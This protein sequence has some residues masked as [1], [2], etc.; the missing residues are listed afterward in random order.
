MHRMR[1]LLRRLSR[2]LSG[3]R[4]LWNNEDWDSVYLLDLM[5][6]K[7]KRMEPV[8]R[9]GL[10]VRG[11]EDARRIRVCIELLDRYIDTDHVDDEELS[12][13]LDTIEIT[14]EGH[15]VSPNRK[16]INSRYKHLQQ[17]EEQQWELLFSYLQ[18]YLRNWWD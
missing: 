7:L 8:I 1:Q 12:E 17:I 3:I 4:I 10:H 13:L 14:E 18:K 2:V 16:Q 6:W 5:R 9:N 11:E 15:I